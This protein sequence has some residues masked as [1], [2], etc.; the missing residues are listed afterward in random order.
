MTATNKFLQSV[1]AH[2]ESKKEEKFSG[3][4]KEYLQLLEKN[5]DITV[6][7]HKRL[8]KQILGVLI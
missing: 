7:A 4:L 6:L 1:K 5:P 3:F 2:Q 8:Y